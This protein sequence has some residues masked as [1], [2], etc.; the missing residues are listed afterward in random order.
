MLIPN[1]NGCER[2]RYRYIIQLLL[3]RVS[4]SASALP[5]IQIGARLGAEF[6]EV[7]LRLPDRDIVEVIGLFVK[8]LAIIMIPIYIVQPL[9][10]LVV[11][12]ERY[13]MVVFYQSALLDLVLPCEVQPALY[14][15]IV[16]TKGLVGAA[17]GDV[18]ALG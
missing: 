14:A 9:L 6:T 13:A 8:P 1:I 16:D 7:L 2:R 15:Q 12:K 4:L 18:Q 17:T 10:V 11:P 5:A 3:A